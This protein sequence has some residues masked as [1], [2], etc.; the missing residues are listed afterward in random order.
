MKRAAALLAC[1]CIWLAGCGGHFALTD[2]STQALRAANDQQRV[3]DDLRRAGAY[4]V[5]GRA[6]QRADQ[7]TTQASRK[8]DSLVEWLADVLFTSLLTPPSTSPAPRR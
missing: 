4:E 6:Q 3:A 2:S 1:A 7:L 8:P 5:A